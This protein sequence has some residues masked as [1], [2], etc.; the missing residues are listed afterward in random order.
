MSHYRTSR[1][2]ELAEQRAAKGPRPRPRVEVDGASFPACRWCGGPCKPPRRTFCSGERTRR[3]KGAVV[4]AGS[5]CVHEWLIRSNA[6][7]LREHVNDRDRGVCAICGTDTVALLVILRVYNRADS[8]W[9]RRP[10]SIT[11]MS[12]EALGYRIRDCFRLALWEADHIIPVVEGGGECGL[13]LVRTLCLP[14]H[15]RESAALAKRRAERRRAEKAVTDAVLA[16]APDDEVARLAAFVDTICGA[17]M[18]T[19]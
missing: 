4:T 14:C 11:A 18:S 6:A 17:Q 16:G 1:Q 19:T 3:R 2:R 15:R 9:A 13:D 5:G 8:G 12:V 10:D 7:Y